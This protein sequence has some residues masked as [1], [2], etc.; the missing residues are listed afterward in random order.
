MSDE[1][2]TTLLPPQEE[3][4][5]EMQN[6]G[7]DWCDRSRRIDL[8]WNVSYS[9]RPGDIVRGVFICAECSKRSPFELKEDTVTFRPGNQWITPLDETVP[10]S[11]QE[12]YAE[13]EL[14]MYAAAYRASAVMGRSAVELALVNVGVTKGTLENKIDNA[15]SQGIIGQE[16]N[17]LAHGSRL[18]GNDAVHIGASVSPGEVPAVLS[19]AANIINH[20][21]S[22][23]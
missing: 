9:K 23:H 20:V 2:S 16:Q 12:R 7:C 11:V 1:R 14:C 4:V 21:F 19:T 15:L 8:P 5:A 17:S 3:G 18:I 22:S 6:I 13:A 10:P